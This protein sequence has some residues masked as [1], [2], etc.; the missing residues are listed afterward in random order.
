VHMRQF[1]Q[2]ALLLH[3][4]EEGRLQPHHIDRLAEE[5]ADFHLS[6]PPAPTGSPLGIPAS[7][8]AA[9]R[10]NFEHLRPVLQSLAQYLGSQP[11]GSAH[12]ILSGQLEQMERTV[13]H[14]NHLTEAGFRQLEPLFRRRYEQGWIRECHGDLHLQN[15]LLEEDRVVIFDCVEFNEEFRWIDIFSDVCFAVMDLIARGYAALG[16]RLLD[17]W[18]ERTDSYSALPAVW[19]QLLY[20]AM[21]RAKVAGIRLQNALDQLQAGEEADPAADWQELQQYVNLGQSFTSSYL[22]ALILTCGVSGSGKTTL[23]TPLVDQLPAVRIRSDVE[24]KRMYGLRPAE[25]PQ[26]EQVAE[27]Y[28]AETSLRVREQLEQRATAVVQSGIPAIVDATFLDRDWRDAFRQL[29]KQL[30][31]PCLIIRF[32][33]EDDVL[34]Q[35]VAARTANGSDASDADLA[36]LEQQLM[37]RE[38]LDDD[39]L[40]LVI[41]CDTTTPDAATR[42]VNDVRRQ[43]EF[44]IAAAK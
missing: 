44:R 41:D 18:V 28:S 7:V 10:G 42:L 22:P 29:A 11:E 1:P 33:A 9:T 23:T 25:R 15:M 8:L 20:R 35:R 37:N 26:P 4:C 6:I 2:E 16:W 30:N 32:L 34:R 14:L 3:V 31:V 21:V 12:G 40:P 17:R 38:P 24:R 13:A 43:L 5:L 27:M 36:V 19:F 39:E